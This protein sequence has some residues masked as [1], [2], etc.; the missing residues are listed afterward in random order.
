MITI[1]YRE[2]DISEIHLIQPLWIQL[3]D[4]VC[5]RATTFRTHFEQ[6]TFEDRKSYFEK[7]AITGSLRIDL[8]FD[9]LRCGGYFGYCVSSLSMEKN[10]EIESIFVHENY[11]SRSIGSGLVKRALAWF[12]ESG[13]VRNRVSVSEGNEAA[14]DFYKKFGFSPRLTV[15]EQKKPE[16]QNKSL[17]V[18]ISSAREK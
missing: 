11:R 5:A 7:I 10:G 9:P 4:Y 2:T 6:M 15:L 17:R 13:S 3:N 12:D 1:E 18:F 14:W 8:A 16:V